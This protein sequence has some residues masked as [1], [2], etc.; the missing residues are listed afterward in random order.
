[1]QMFYWT[2]WQSEKKTLLIPNRVIL[3]EE[4]TSLFTWNI[5]NGRR[6][7]VHSGCKLMFL[8]GVT[9]CSQCFLKMRLKKPMKVKQGK[10]KMHY[11][12]YVVTQADIYHPDGVSFSFF[13]FFT[14]YLDICSVFIL[15]FKCLNKLIHNTTLSF[16]FLL[17]L[18]QNHRFTCASLRKV[19]CEGK[20]LYLAGDIIQTL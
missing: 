10:L 6:C 12:K 3:W 17:Y 5:T 4:M 18:N 9:H 19:H 15:T 14:N 11:V 8:M 16:E 7:C 13:F 2:T 20:H 1:M